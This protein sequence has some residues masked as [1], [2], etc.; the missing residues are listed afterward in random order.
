MKNN[1]G[2]S[3]GSE[4]NHRGLKAVEHRGRAFSHSG[5]PPGL[6][7]E[8]TKLKN[9]TAEKIA[10]IDQLNISEVRWSL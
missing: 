9:H 4:E 1:A 2:W 10:E 8:Y 6:P 7:I 5:I 3:G